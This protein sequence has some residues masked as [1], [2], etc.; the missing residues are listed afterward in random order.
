LDAKTLRKKTSVSL[1]GDLL[2]EAN[3]VARKHGIS[4]S[5][6]VKR[7][8]EADLAERRGRPL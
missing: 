1:P 7:V 5:E 4:L 2:R 6:Y 8:V 3:L